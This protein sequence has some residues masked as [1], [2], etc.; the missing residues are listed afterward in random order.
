MTSFREKLRMRKRFLSIRQLFCK[1]AYNAYWQ[2][3]YD[4][5]DVIFSNRCTRCGKVKEVRMPADNVKPA[6]E[7]YIWLRKQHKA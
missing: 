4:E 3:D 2:T 5:G 7:H 1:H 6:W